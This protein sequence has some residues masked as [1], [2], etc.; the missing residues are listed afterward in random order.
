MLKLYCIKIANAMPYNMHK[1]KIFALIFLIVSATGCTK[2]IQKIYRV[3][4]RIEIDEA[5][6]GDT[7]RDDSKDLKIIQKECNKLEFVGSH[8]I[9]WL[10]SKEVRIISTSEFKIPILKTKKVKYV[11]VFGHDMETDLKIAGNCLGKEY[12]VEG[13]KK[14]FDNRYN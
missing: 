2:P 11:N 13:D 8:T 4:N 3:L 1:I 5:A 7:Y 9:D 10:L 14:I 6:S 12:I